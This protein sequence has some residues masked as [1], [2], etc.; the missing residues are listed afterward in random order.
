M[1]EAELAQHFIDYFSDHEIFKEVPMNGICDIVARHGNIVTAIEV[2]KQFSF[3]VIEQALKKKPCAHYV[4]VA[5]PKG[6]NYHFRYKLCNMLGIGCLEY[7]EYNVNYHGSKRYTKEG[8]L[9]VTE[10]VRPQLN[11]RPKLPK[12]HDWMKRSVA[13]SQ[14]ERMTSFKYFSECFKK[15]LRSYNGKPVSPKE[16]YSKM[17]KHYNSI[18]SFR[19]SIVKYCERGIIDGVDFIDGCFVLSTTDTN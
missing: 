5:I 8:E 4:Y 9:H 6:K 3:E 1:S 18:S 19:S 10:T 2:K 15:E 7:S 13:G 14:G 17:P 16:I 12:L 11:R